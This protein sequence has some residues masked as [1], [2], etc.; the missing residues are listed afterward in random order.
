MKK[1]WHKLI[2]LLF[3][4]TNIQVYAGEIEIQPTMFSRSNAQDRIWV[5]SFQLVW[6]DFMDKIV[7]NPIRFREGTPRIVYELNQQ[8]FTANDLSERSY[9]KYTGKVTKSTKR[10]IEKGIRKKF[11]ETSDLLD[12]LDL[13]ARGDMFIVYAMLKKDF[14]FVNEFD[15]LGHSVFG[16]DDTAEYFGIGENSNP[17]LGQGIEVLFYNDSNDYAILLKTK[18]DDEVLLYKNASNKSFNFIYEDL[19][20]KQNV[21]NGV[22]EFKNVDELKIPN[23]D[24]FTEKSYKELTNKR[25][26]GTNMVINQ[27]LQTIRFNM[28]SKGVKLKSEAGLTA[29][30]T[31]LLPPEELTPRLFYFD[32]TFVIFLRENAKKEPYF[33]MRVNDIKN[34]QKSK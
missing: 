3:L 2:I 1:L 22:K 11:K 31:S 34:F 20:K 8:S 24:L 33:A 30:T 9:Y 16:E 27:A 13:T 23:I 12:K 4:I 29:V 19:L 15:K 14:E 25:I 17:I 21:F 5:G 6:N 28:N 7:H 18:N 10:N 26:M 32:K